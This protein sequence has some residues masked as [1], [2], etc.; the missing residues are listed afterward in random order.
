MVVSF[1]S[2]ENINDQFNV[3]VYY[4][5]HCLTVAV[6]FIAIQPTNKNTTYIPKFVQIGLQNIRRIFSKCAGKAYKIANFLQ[7]MVTI[8]KHCFYASACSSRP[9][10]RTSCFRVVRT[11]VRPSVNTYN[12]RDAIIFVHSYQ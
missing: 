7:M 12:P 9:R 4:R 1:Q 10:Q 6:F 3:L 5:L 8:G 11:A 2:A